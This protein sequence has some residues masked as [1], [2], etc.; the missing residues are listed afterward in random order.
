MLV[1]CP[2]IIRITNGDLRERDSSSRASSSAKL[3]HR[4]G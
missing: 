1:G 4:A 2:A 3:Y